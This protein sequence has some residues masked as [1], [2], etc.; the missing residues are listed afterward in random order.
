MNYAKKKT[1]IDGQY[2]ESMDQKKKEMING[3]KYMNFFQ[4]NMLC[5]NSNSTF[6]VY[7]GGNFSLIK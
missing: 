4:G 5:C 2:F 3:G 1:V 6:K 7:V